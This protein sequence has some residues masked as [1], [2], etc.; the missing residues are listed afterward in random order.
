MTMY[1]LLVGLLDGVE[2]LVLQGRFH[3][4]EGYR[5]WQVITK[6]S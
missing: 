3:A 1:R 4:Y 5:L 2:V 6:D